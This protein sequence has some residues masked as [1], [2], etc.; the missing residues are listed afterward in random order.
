MVSRLTFRDKCPD[1]CWQKQLRDKYLAEGIP[2]V[3]NLDVK[4]AVVRPVSRHLAEQTIYKYEWLGT[5]AATSLH[6]G[7][8]FVI[9]APV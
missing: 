5:M 8:F 7:I 6:Y 3:P 1:V 2:P 9:I 4:R